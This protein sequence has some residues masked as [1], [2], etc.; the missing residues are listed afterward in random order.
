MEEQLLDVLTEGVAA[1]VF[2]G[3]VVGVLKEGQRTII[4]VGRFAYE[5]SSPAVAEETLYDT[6]SIT[7]S[8]PVGLLTLKFIEEGKLSL[9]D[10][11]NTFIPEITRPHAEQGR[12]RHL[13]TYSYILKKNSDPQYKVE[14]LTARDILEYLFTRE[15][16]YLSGAHYQYSNAPANLLGLIL[17]RVS[18]ERLYKLSTRIILDP[19]EMRRST[20]SPADTKSIPPT[21]V[22]SWRGVV[23]GV[24]HDEQAFIL[25]RD[26]QDS[27][28]SGLF[29]P[30]ND[31]LHIA[32]MVLAN[33][34]FKGRR[35]F[36]P[37]TIELMRTNALADI[38]ASCGIGWE[39]DQPHFMGKYSHAHMLGKTG[40]TGTSIVIDPRTKRACVLLSNRTYPQ[41]ANIEA[42]RAVRRTVADIV[43]AP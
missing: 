21:E 12:I 11:V 14:A 40:F 32:E 18:G 31:L 24:V 43:F 25:Q 5:Q 36:K 35:L 39:L 17:E 30:A 37:E 2:P 29:A 10:R 19:L 33:G 3:A 41:R 9:D 34:V 13:L 38:G 23:Q 7:K 4:P 22:D 42:S 8:I 26:G 16:E 27:G 1:R 15:F 28:A 6:A 20:F